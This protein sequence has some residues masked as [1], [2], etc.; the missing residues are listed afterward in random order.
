ME[1]LE[2][3]EPPRKRPKIKESLKGATPYP[4]KKKKLDSVGSRPGHPNN[5][6]FQESARLASRADV[7]VPGFLDRFYNAL[8]PE[9]HRKNFPGIWSV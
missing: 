6:E 3:D 9:E 2:D 5:K 8:I 1:P 7:Q 4:K